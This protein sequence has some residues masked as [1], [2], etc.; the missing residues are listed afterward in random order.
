MLA[1]EPPPS[2][3]LAYNP[4]TPRRLSGFSP[5]R[6]LIA[7][8][9]ST[10]AH[11]P[12]SG[13]PVV[14]IPTPRPPTSP[15]VGRT[16]SSS[17]ITGSDSG[18]S[19]SA[20]S[21]APSPLPLPRTTT[22][23]STFANE[24][25]QSPSFYLKPSPPL[26]DSSASKT[27]MELLAESM[28]GRML[29][30]IPKK[31]RLYNKSLEMLE[32]A[33]IKFTRSHRLDVCLVQNHPIALVFLPASD[34]PRFVAHGNVDMGITGQ[35]TILESRTEEG[36]TQVLKLG[37]GGCK[38]QV[39]V[40]EKGPIHCIEQLAGKRVVSSYTTL[41]RDYFRKLDERLGLVGAGNE[42]GSTQVQYVGG[43]VEAACALGLADGIVDLVESG[44]TMRAAGL[45]AIDTVMTTEAVL[46]KSTNVKHPDLVPLIKRI[47]SRI[48]G[49]V[50]SNKY[51]ICQY[52]VPRE[53]LPIV[54]KI[55]PGR[56]A[57]TIS[58]IEDDGWVAVSAMVEKSKVANV[59]DELV[60]AGAEDTFIVALQNCRVE[61]R[62]GS[63][64]LPVAEEEQEQ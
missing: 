36:V 37:F 15:I 55:T 26:S 44:E 43:S 13:S 1:S 45:H 56:R 17:S 53:L 48:A 18:S 11:I 24:A 54:T 6:Q 64:E 21:L 12:S 31:G 5:P 8:S 59:M 50:A 61:T 52:N 10:T 62:L 22:A 34:I 19:G 46:I 3:K 2:R 16:K 30:A 29:F 28:K 39:Q 33:D 42:G 60:E 51:V 58:S 14:S 20:L 38:L 40:P 23:A 4:R 25:N 47:T 7:A 57:P 41:A 35:D 32:G 27:P 9:Q 49:F 63:S